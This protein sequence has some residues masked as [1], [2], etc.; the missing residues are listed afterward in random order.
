MHYIHFRL[1][2][3]Y[4]THVTTVHFTAGS[5]VHQKVQEL[6][7]VWQTFGH[8]DFWSFTMFP[9]LP[10]Q[11]LDKLRDRWTNTGLWEKLEQHKTVITEPRGGKGD[12]DELLQTYYDAI[13]Y[14]EG[15]GEAHSARW[16]SA[17][18][19]N[20]CKTHFCPFVMGFF[21][22]D[23][24]LLIAVC[25]G[26]VSEGL[27]FTDDNARAVVTIGIPFPNIK[28]LQVTTQFLLILHRTFD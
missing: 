7:I 20:A 8:Y 14:G 13:K 18:E 3:V 5:S 6:F 2:P 27:D 24:A 15:R 12:F 22:T 4:V 1:H 23:G 11:M 10:G 26:K 21:V 28:D 25:R 19:M 9:L 16:P 17:L